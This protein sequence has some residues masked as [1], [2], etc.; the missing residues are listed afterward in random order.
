MHGLQRVHVHISDFLHQDKKAQ[1]E[2]NV[3]FSFCSNAI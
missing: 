2:A 1:D 3:Q